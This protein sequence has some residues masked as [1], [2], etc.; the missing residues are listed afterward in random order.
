MLA[1]LA[2]PEKSRKVE[3]VRRYEEPAWTSVRVTASARVHLG[4]LDLNGGLGRRFGSIGLS[5]DAFWTEVCLAKSHGFSVSG[6]EQDRSARLA[7]RFAEKMGLNTAKSLTVTRAIPA[8]A[9]L[10][11]GT[12]LAL[13]IAAAFRRLHALPPDAQGDA[14]LLDRGERSGIGAALF[15]Q[16]G[17]VVDAGRGPATVVP[18][19]IARLEFPREWRIV[20]V[21][22]RTVRGAHGEVERRAFAGLPAFPAL[23]AAEICRLTLMQILPGVAERDIE[24]FAAGVERL[25]EI[26]GV[27]FAPAQ[28]GGRF[29]SAGVGRAMERMKAC[30]ARGIGQSSWGPTGFAF[31]ADQDEAESL[32]QAAGAHDEPGLEVK[33][34]KA[35][36]RGVRVETN[37]GATL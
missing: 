16:G 30:G 9:G 11:S 26:V 37:A 17:L 12:Q 36:D 5:V 34:C 4:F 22:D 8:H 27:Y 33:I 21:L 13:A 32:A 18:P 6:E 35:L 28:G 31:A 23:A 15:E 10:G 29:T 14:R 7:I 20:L 1:R 25:Q 19:V 24:A 3:Y 2:K